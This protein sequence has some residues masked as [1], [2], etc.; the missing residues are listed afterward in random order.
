MNPRQ[1]NGQRESWGG[2]TLHPYHELGIDVE[3][4]L[5]LDEDGLP[6]APERKQA[7]RETA[8]GEA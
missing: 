7:E 3:E 8:E 1:S 5:P 4:F 6:L 2:E